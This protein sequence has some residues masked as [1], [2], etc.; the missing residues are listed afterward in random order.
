ME[1]KSIGPMTKSES[2]KQTDRKKKKKS[3]AAQTTKPEVKD[4]SVKEAQTEK[5]VGKVIQ[6][7]I[8]NRELKWLYPDDVT[9]TLTRKSWRQKARNEIQ[10]LEKRIFN[11][12]NAEGEITQENKKK[13][14]KLKKEIQEKRE[15][16]LA[17]PNVEV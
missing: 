14:N 1:T 6:Q 5:N 7:T 8:V 12:M 13:A 11:L 3:S 17:N 15:V 10:R 9:D 4:G 2:D 16:Y